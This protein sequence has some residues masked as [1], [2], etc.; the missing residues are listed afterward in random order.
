MQSARDELFDLSD[1]THVFRQERGVD[2]LGL[3]SIVWVYKLGEKGILHIPQLLEG[4]IRRLGRVLMVVMFST[5]P[6][7]G[8]R[9]AIRLPIRLFTTP[10]GSQRQGQRTPVEEN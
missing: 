7:R 4:E 1:S 5:V 10:L 8:R 3:D 6:L 9:R 2:A